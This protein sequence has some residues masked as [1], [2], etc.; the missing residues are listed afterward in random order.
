MN[1]KWIDSLSNPEILRIVRFIF[2]GGA[3]FLLSTGIY[4]SLSRWLW[5][6]GNH[7]VENVIA[8]TITALFNYS[9]HRTWTF[10]S[11]GKHRD[12][13]WRYLFVMISAM[14]IQAG[15]FWLGHDVLGVYDFALII[16]LAGVVPIYTYVMHRWFTFPTLTDV[17]CDG[18]A[19][20][21]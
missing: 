3:S 15:L 2:V 14:A 5:V 20:S 4:A 6:G 1:M 10:R 9:A 17:P 12:H 19:T 16:I 21:S 11:S 18:N 7:S 13:L 8:I